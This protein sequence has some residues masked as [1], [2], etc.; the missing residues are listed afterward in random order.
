MFEPYFSLSTDLLSASHGAVL[1]GA[2]A[3]GAIIGW[4]TAI[5][6]KNKNL[7][8]REEQLKQSVVQLRLEQE[9]LE[10]DL[11][12]YGATIGETKKPEIK[13]IREKTNEFHKYI[14]ENDEYSVDGI[15]DALEAFNAGITNADGCIRR[16]D[17]IYLENALVQ[18]GNF[19]E[20]VDQIKNWPSE[21]EADVHL[22]KLESELQTVIEN[23]AKRYYVQEGKTQSEIDE[24]FSD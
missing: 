6:W 19:W 24:V 3:I 8:Q 18:G 1:L 17:I 10:T 20:L 22:A 7:K 4:V 12:N 13:N 2:G 11:N 14:L 23:F 9:K 16:G 15:Q 5:L 21:I